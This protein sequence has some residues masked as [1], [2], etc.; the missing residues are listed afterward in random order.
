MPRLQVNIPD[1]IFCDNKLVVK[2]PDKYVT[3]DVA[4][5]KVLASWKDS[6]LSFE[7][8]NTDGS[9]RMDRELSPKNQERRSEIEQLIRERKVVQRP[10]LG[11][12]LMDNI[13]IG[14]GR[15]VFMT[16]ATQGYS[17]VS[18]HIRKAQQDEFKGY[19]V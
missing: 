3:V 17:V 6:I 4:L 7:F 12:G 14:S 2:E 11:I 13:E 16:L 10:I 19:I 18:V 9:L 8:L 1:A 15:D 5:E